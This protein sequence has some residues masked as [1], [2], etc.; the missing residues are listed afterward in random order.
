M[1]RYFLVNEKNA[2]LL[3]VGEH[4][5]FTIRKLQIAEWIIDTETGYLREFNFH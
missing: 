3:F 5:L 4:A 1:Q 2:T